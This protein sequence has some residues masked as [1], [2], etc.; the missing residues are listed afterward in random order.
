[1]AL[2]A[3]VE[4]LEGIDESLRSHYTKGE[5]GKFTLAVES[6]GGLVLENVDGLKTALS[7][8]RTAKEAALTSVKAFEGID[9]NA[10]RT[11]I[12]DLKKLQESDPEGKAAE[13]VRQRTE[14][15]TTEF[16][17]KN[18][19]L[20]DELA[21]ANKTINTLVLDGTARSAIAAEKGNVTLLMPH[22]MPQLS[23]KTSDAGAMSTVVLDAK[24]QPRPVVENG[25]VRD[26]TAAEL[27]KE[28]SGDKSF[29]S[30]FAGKEVNGTK[31]RSGVIGRDGK[32]TVDKDFKSP[33]LEQADAIANLA[34]ALKRE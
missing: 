24:G 18:Q 5:D 9:V 21:K 2:K 1:M 25:V 13:I 33:N 17:T 6:V 34:T 10:A 8:E 29:A 32:P 4:N 14:A 27:V 26:M 7:S 12:A 16:S 28:M 19:A 11:A 20:S 31:G 30:A 23:L 22:V 3:I 15:I